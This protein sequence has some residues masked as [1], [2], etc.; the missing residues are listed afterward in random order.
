MNKLH[1]RNKNIN[2]KNLELKI[3]QYFDNEQILHIIHLYYENDFYCE[4]M[5]YDGKQNSY[6]LYFYKP[7]IEIKTIAPITIINKIP[8][9]TNDLFTILKYNYINR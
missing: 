2:N 7:L 5:Y 6:W 8:F 3:K 1:N 4:K 9:Q